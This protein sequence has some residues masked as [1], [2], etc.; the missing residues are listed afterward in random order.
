MKNKI[1]F[2][3]FID[4]ITKDK[5]IITSNIKKYSK[6]KINK[7]FFKYKNIEISSFSNKIF[8]KFNNII[9]IKNKSEI[10]LKKY[11]LNKY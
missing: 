9:N 11:K 7:L 5:F 10:F 2:I 1:N 6:K 3:I 8:N 4:I